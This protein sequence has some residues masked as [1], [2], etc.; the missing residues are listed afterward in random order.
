MEYMTYLNPMNQV[1]SQ[2]DRLNSRME[3]DMWDNLKVQ[4]VMEKVSKFGLIIPFT[5]GTG[6]TI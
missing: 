4:N 6:K 5:K 2:K 3:K 1:L